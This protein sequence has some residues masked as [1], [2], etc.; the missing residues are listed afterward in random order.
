MAFSAI[1]RVGS[2]W[3]KRKPI[4][5]MRDFR[6]IIGNKLGDFRQNRMAHCKT[7]RKAEKIL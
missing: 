4:L 2:F 3:P 1:G 7:L 6:H 5:K